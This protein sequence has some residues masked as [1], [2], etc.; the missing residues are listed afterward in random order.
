MKPTA[1]AFVDGRH[2]LRDGVLRI[3]DLTILTGPNDSGKTSTLENLRRALGPRAEAAS[4]GRVIVFATATGDEIAMLVANRL[5]QLQVAAAL[6]EGEEPGRELH[7]GEG[8]RLQL[9]EP[10]TSGPLQDRTKV[11][12]RI[13]EMVQQGGTV[14]FENAGSTLGLL[15]VE[16]TVWQV[17]LCQP[18]AERTDFDPQAVRE[19]RTDEGMLI[20]VVHEEAPV[21]VIPLGS[22]S[23]PE[24]GGLSLLPRPAVL[25]ADF[26]DTKARLERAIGQLAVNLRVQ[27]ETDDVYDE[28]ARHGFD[29]RES[30]LLSD[31][32]GTRVHIDPTVISLCNATA[33]LCEEALPA[34]VRSRYDILLTPNPILIWETAGRCQIQLRG[35]EDDSE[36]DVSEVADGFRLWIQL[37]LLESAQ[38]LNDRAALLYYLANRNPPED[39]DGELSELEALISEA[40]A[41]VDGLYRG[42]LAPELVLA[43][44]RLDQLAD[45]LS[46]HPTQGSLFDMRLLLELLRG[47]LYLIDEPERHLHPALARDAAKWL[48]LRMDA[49]RAQ[50]VIVTHSPAFIDAPG[51]SSI[52]V[53]RGRSQTV[54]RSFP[55]SEL[56]A[57]DRIAE[58]MGFDRGELLAR[59]R[60]V[61]FVEGS[62]DRVVLEELFSDELRQK[63]ILID[64]Y[65]GIGHIEAITENP[66]LRYTGAAAAV[67]VDDVSADTIRQ[68]KNDPGFARSLRGNNEAA[69]LARLLR[70]AAELEKSVEPL[71]HGAKDIFFLLHD[72]AL[73]DI[74]DSWSGH[75]EAARR[76]AE[77]REA[78]SREGFKSFYQREC[79]I[80]VSVE[81]CRTAARHMAKAG[82]RPTALVEVIDQAERLGLR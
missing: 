43:P 34:F 73:H 28:A 46:D 6:D 49:A 51:A 31:L 77:H 40:R 13:R 17:A 32:D 74:S 8:L 5:R 18:S 61:L 39:A 20:G 27:T 62:M 53:G 58:E 66:L 67:L 9:A 42:E 54:F 2:P 45:W 37:A 57:L 3:T 69:A 7:V 24:G 29:D 75:A 10:A 71:S 26:A 22:T 4:P 52:Y 59:V 48:A 60:S 68:L 35:R 38:R 76:Y 47:T 55:P 33:A 15:D 81:T 14:A 12:A 80:E 64:V 79:G 70:R 50:A 82:R 41:E 56:T 44:N 65:A 1:Y 21:P 16:Q 25:P 72:D 30:W 78:G 63:G 36:F 11:W 19:W 23:L